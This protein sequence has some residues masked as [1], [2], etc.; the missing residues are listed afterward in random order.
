MCGCR[1]EKVGHL[2]NVEGKG[3]MSIMLP[4]L[5]FLLLSLLRATGC[6]SEAAPAPCWASG[7]GHSLSSRWWGSGGKG[8]PFN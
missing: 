7:V 2:K 6:R 1:D 3:Q 5:Y 4:N 8:E